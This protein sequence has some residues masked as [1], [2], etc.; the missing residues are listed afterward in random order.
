MVLGFS[1]V[2]TRVALEGRAIE[3]ADAVTSPSQDVL[4]QVRAHY[5][6]ALPNARVIPNPGPHV[7]SEEAWNLEASRP[8]QLVFVGRFDRHK[9]GDLVIRAFAQL[10][11]RDPEL[12]L[13]FAG[14]DRG[15][16]DEF[17]GAPRSLQEYVQEHV[18]EALRSRLLLLGHTL[19]SRLAELRRQSRVCIVA[20]RYETFGMTA[21]EALACGCPIVAPAVGGIR[22]IIQHERTGLLFPPT[23]VD[24]MVAHIERLL[25]D[26]GLA[27]DLAA[28]ARAAFVARFRPEVVA[29]ATLD[30]YEEIVQAPLAVRQ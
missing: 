4:D 11:A 26:P 21:L 8:K 28:S 14:P 20:S 29:K 17:G 5:R 23:D 15:L 3:R 7:P 1:M 30:L 10:A 12:E 22:E 2:S 18:P 19:P 27:T 9:G 6:L 25:Q 13:V 24:A 16:S